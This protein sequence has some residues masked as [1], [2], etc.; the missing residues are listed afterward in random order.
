MAVTCLFIDIRLFSL[1]LRNS[2]QK[3][4]LMFL[5]RVE[6]NVTFSLLPMTSQ[7]VQITLRFKTCFCLC[8]HNVFGVYLLRKIFLRAEE[9]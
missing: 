6:L 7:S 3:T 1:I 2:K 5:P 8:L 9:V 4:Q